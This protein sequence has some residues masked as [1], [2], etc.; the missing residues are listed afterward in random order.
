LQSEEY[1]EFLPTD[2]SLPQEESLMGMQ[3]TERRGNKRRMKTSAEQSQPAALVRAL[4][5]SYQYKDDFQK[6]PLHP[7]C[8]L[9][10]F[11]RHTH[12]NNY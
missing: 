4:V 3:E 8:F 10:T 9:F 7:S 2:T 1:N 6:N 5:F 11:L 12:V